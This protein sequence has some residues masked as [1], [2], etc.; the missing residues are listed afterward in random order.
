MQIINHKF[1]LHVST[2]VSLLCFFVFRRND[3]IVNDL[4]GDATALSTRFLAIMLLA[5][6]KCK[7]IITPS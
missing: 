6:K 3:K 4:A 7:A 5:A 1:Y 2:S